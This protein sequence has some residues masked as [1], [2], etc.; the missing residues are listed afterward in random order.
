MSDGL[1]Y[2]FYIDYIKPEEP[3][4]VRAAADEDLPQHLAV[5]CD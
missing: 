2:I 5:P 3:S 1:K 4:I